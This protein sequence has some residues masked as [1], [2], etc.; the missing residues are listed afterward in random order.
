MNYVYSEEN[1]NITRV[2]NELL[3]KYDLTSDNEE[4]PKTTSKKFAK[5]DTKFH[6]E[7]Y[8]SKVMHGY[9]YR[10]IE[11]DEKTDHNNSKS[12]TKN[13]I[14]TSHFEGYIAAIQDQEI[15]TKYLLNKRA[16]DVGK[17][18]PCDN[19]CCLC[20]TN[21]EDVIHI[22]SC[23]PFMSALYYLPMRHDMVAKI[24]HKEIIKKYHP[25]IEAPNEI[26]E[27]EYIQKLGDNEYCWNLSINTAQKVQHNKPDLVIWNTKEKTCDI[28]EVS[29]PADI[30]ITK[31]E[32]RK[33]STY[34][35]LVPNL[36]IM[37]PN[38]H[39]RI[40][41][42]I[43]GALGSIPKWLHGFNNFGSKRSI[44]KL[45]S[46]SATGTVKICK[47]FLKFQ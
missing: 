9:F 30:N 28:I 41:P 20:K 33:L 36:Q 18:P 29:C 24:L 10:T 19:K 47:S 13:R 45:Q 22:I 31:K 40:T 6:Y 11:K 34:V 23:C 44:G 5:A 3:Q 1:N 8:T 25:E 17:E 37:Y 38:Y 39:Y 35:P 21:V 32:E 14:L 42:T 26:N 43:V 16:R 46:I 12:W 7:K 27:Q 4:Q 2:G 15:P